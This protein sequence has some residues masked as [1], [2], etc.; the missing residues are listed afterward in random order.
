MIW[1]ESMTAINRRRINADDAHD[2]CDDGRPR[3]GCCGGHGALRDGHRDGRGEGM[4]GMD[5]TLGCDAHDVHGAHGCDDCWNDGDC[6][7]GLW[8]WYARNLYL[9]INA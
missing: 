6:T 9:R 2:C 4:A 3:G 8:C 5:W 7:H 1:F